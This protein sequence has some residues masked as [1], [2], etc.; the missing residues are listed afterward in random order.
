MKKKFVIITISYIIGLIWGLYFYSNITLIFCLIFFIIFLIR[1]KKFIYINI[2]IITISCIYNYKIKE[3]YDL[4]YKEIKN[5]EIVGTIIKDPVDKEYSKQYI[6]KVISVNGSTNFK[7]T[8]LLINSKTSKSNNVNAQYGDLISIVGEFELAKVNTNYKGF[9]YNE[10]LRSK[11]IYGIVQTKSNDIKIYHHNDVSLYDKS[12]YDKSLYDKSLYN[13]YNI[14]KQK[15]YSILPK[16]SAS[17]CTALILGDKSN[18]EEQVIEN[19]SESNLSHILA[20]SGMHM[21][22]IIL[23]FSFILKFCDK[24]KSNFTII[25]IIIIFCNLVGNSESIVRAS[26][27]SII[28]ILGADI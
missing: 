7:N 9:N 24:R 1:K 10:Y 25:F 6:I 27:M 28:Y 17:I 8:R 18:I 14:L 16:E 26:I 3:N 23:I 11:K 22:Y 15:I 19:F 12:L 2:L 20:I 21:S 5:V 4:K 13:F